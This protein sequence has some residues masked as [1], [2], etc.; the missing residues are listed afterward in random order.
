M[1][2]APD[3]SQF[4]KA[5][6]VRGLVGS[7]LTDEVVEA[8]GAGFVDEIGAAGLEVMVGHDMRDSSPA[9]WCKKY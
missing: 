8:L 5:Y 6:D 7:Q 4:I 3:L 1:S 9:D 2:T